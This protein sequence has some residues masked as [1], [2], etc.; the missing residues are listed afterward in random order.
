MEAVYWLTKTVT[1]S[2]GKRVDH[3]VRK[4]EQRVYLGENSSISQPNINN[5][6]QLGITQPENQTKEE[7]K[8]V[9]QEYFEGVKNRMNAEYTKR[10]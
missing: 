5:I 7:A 6:E 1:R 2:I 10:D 8:K 4:M 3:K 9:I